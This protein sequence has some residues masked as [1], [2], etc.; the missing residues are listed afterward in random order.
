MVR[1]ELPT[2][3]NRLVE[4]R[5]GIEVEQEIVAEDLANNLR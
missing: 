2:I 3:I 5:V 4:L 1:V